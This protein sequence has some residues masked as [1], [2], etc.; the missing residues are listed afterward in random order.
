MPGTEDS[1]Y[2]RIGWA[3]VRKCTAGLAIEQKLTISASKYLGI[4][5]AVVRGNRDRPSFIKYS[6][7]STQIEEARSK[8]VVSTVIFSD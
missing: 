1:G 5:A 2:D 7:Y 3:G 6:P 8:P 4:S